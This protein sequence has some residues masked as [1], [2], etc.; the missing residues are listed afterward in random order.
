MALKLATLPKEGGRD[1]WSRTLGG[2]E[3]KAKGDAGGG[4]QK[5]FPKERSGASTPVEKR[6]PDARKG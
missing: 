3:E 5:L 4:K 2:K 1:A 6:R